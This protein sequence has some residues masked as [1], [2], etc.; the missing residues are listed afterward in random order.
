MIMHLNYIH[1]LVGSGEYTVPGSDPFTFLRVYLKSPLCLLNY[2]FLDR[3]KGITFRYMWNVHN[4]WG[5]FQPSGFLF[6]SVLF[7][8]QNT[9]WA[10]E[11]IVCRNVVCSKG[12]VFGAVRSPQS[13]LI[14]T[15]KH[16]SQRRLWFCHI[17]LAPFYF[18]WTPLWLEPRKVFIC[19]TEMYWPTMC[20][21]TATLCL[22]KNKHI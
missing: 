9:L 13:I 19:P 5:K 22:W 17:T 20:Q 7:Q 6:C 3:I 18:T 15:D 21:L 14:Y 11:T 10:A 2:S 8:L 4:Q 1:W 16:V 12:H